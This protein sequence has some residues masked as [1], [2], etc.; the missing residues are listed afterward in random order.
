MI[1]LDHW[2]R[3]NRADPYTEPNSCFSDSSDSLNSL[4]SMKVPLHLEKTPMLSK[5]ATF[6]YI[7]WVRSIFTHDS[8]NDRPRSVCWFSHEKNLPVCHLTGKRLI[9]L[10]IKMA[11]EGIATWK[12]QWRNVCIWNLQKI[13]CTWQCL[14]TL[15][16]CIVNGN[17][18]KW[19]TETYWKARMWNAEASNLSFRTVS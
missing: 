5:L 17:M 10:C 15:T 16:V 19:N 13:G 4:N 9:N 11:G 12:L 1:P 3:G 14:I 18:F 2:A 7:H 6:P 8:Q